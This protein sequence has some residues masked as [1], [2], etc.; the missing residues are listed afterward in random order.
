[1]TGVVCVYFGRRDEC[2]ECGGF[3][4]TG[5]PY[6]SHDCAADAA[7]RLA[8]IEETVRARRAREDAFAAE[9]DRLRALGHSDEEIDVLLA[10]MPA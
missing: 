5:D 2:H 7:A 4:Q 10:G 1:M 3:N 8:Q 9:C 6:C